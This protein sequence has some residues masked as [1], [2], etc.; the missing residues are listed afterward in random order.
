MKMDTLM[1]RILPISQ[2]QTD[3]DPKNNSFESV[4]IWDDAER[5]KKTIQLC[6]Y[7]ITEFLPLNTT[8]TID[9][10]GFCIT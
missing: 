8:H 1:I 10:M 2:Q 6:A 5:G 3:A 9:M 4:I 7:L